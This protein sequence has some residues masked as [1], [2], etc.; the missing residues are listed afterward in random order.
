MVTGRRTDTFVRDDG[1]TVP[2]AFFIHFI[3][4]VHNSGWLKKTQIIQQDYNSVLIKMVVKDPPRAK[5]LD[6]IRGSLQRVL[7]SACRVEFEFV[8]DISPLPSGKYRYT[9]SHVARR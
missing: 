7:G 2:G 9:I 4:V 3:G 1:S 5:A 8:D 6:E